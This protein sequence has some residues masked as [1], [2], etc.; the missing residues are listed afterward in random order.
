MEYGGSMEKINDSVSVGIFFVKQITRRTERLA[1]VTVL[2][3]LFTQ[4]GGG[5]GCIGKH[6]LKVR[7]I[8]GP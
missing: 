5:R 8:Q 3:I 6:P 2:Q 7:E 1:A 4:S